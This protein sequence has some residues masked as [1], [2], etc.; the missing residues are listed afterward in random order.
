MFTSFETMTKLSPE[1]SLKPFH[2]FHTDVKAEWLAGFDSIESLTYLLGEVK[3]RALDLMVLG[4]GSNVLFTQ[5]VKGAVLVNKIDHIEV[6]KEDEDEL[7]DELE[8]GAV[9]GDSED[10]VTDSEDAAG[11]EE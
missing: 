1:V 2:T 6:V 10:A 11:E 7:E 8:E 9:E 3:E 4:G 5:D